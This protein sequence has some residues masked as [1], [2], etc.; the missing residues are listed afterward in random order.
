MSRILRF[1]EGTS[2][3]TVVAD[4]GDKGDGADLAWALRD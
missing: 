1:A 4:F 3:P 2:V